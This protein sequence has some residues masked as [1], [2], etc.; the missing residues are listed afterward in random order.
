MEESQVLGR[1]QEL[2]DIEHKLWQKEAEGTATAEDR[3]QL[4]EV[5]V[6]LDQCWDLMRQRRALKRAGRDPDQASP[7]PPEIVETY[8]Q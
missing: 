6:K 4:K 8:E 1:I 7:R 5:E 2:V 3:R